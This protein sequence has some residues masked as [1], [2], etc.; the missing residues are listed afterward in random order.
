MMGCK[1]EVSGQRNGLC[2]WS[3]ESKQTN[4]LVVA[5]FYLVK[6]MASYKIVDFAIRRGY[7]DCESC[8]DDACPRCGA[9]VVE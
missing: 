7:E 5:L 1:Y 2:P 6:M 8:G 9:K 4:S 3:G